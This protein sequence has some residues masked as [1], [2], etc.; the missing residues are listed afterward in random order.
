M[1][2]IP[3]LLDAMFPTIN[4]PEDWIT[5]NLDDLAKKFYADNPTGSTKNRKGN[6]LLDPTQLELQMA[7]QGVGLKSYG[8]HLEDRS[9]IWRGHYMMPDRPIHV[10]VDINVAPMTAVCLPAEGALIGDT[11]DNDQQGGW[12]GKLL[13]RI[14][15]KLVIFAHL[16]PNLL[17]EVRGKTYPAGTPI[18][19]VGRKTNNGGW[20]SHLHIQVVDSL[21]DVD[22]D[23]YQAPN[24]NLRGRFPSPLNFLCSLMGG[25]D[26][27]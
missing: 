13:F 18:G 14:G 5:V 2:D 8:G 12:G 21:E 11:V 17:L 3:K 16:D 6:S 10:G 22:E 26:G 15:G 19:V 4:S 27:N 20:H 7:V 23:G 9:N 24:T 25:L 1:L